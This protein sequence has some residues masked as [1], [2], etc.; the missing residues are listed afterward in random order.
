M[1]EEFNLFRGYIFHRSQNTPEIGDKK[2]LKV[3]ATLI[4]ESDEEKIIEDTPNWALSRFPIEFKRGGREWDP[5]DDRDGH[6]VESPALT[7]RHVR[8]QLISYARKVCSYQHRT[9]LL[10]LF[11][12]GEE[13]RMLHWDRS[14]LAFTPA[15]NYLESV[16]NMRLLLQFLYGFVVL[17]D[18]TQGLD[19]TAV[20]LSKESCGWKRMEVLGLASR[21]DLAHEERLIPQDFELPAGFA[22]PSADASESPL[23][24]AG[25][26]HRDPTEVCD[27]SLDHKTL[28]P[29]V[30]PVWKYMRELFRQSITSDYP[31]YS[32]TVGGRRFLVAKPV[33]EA[34]G[35]VSRGT[36]GYIALD[37]ETQRFVFLKDAWRPF[38]DGVQKEGDV[39]FKL[40]KEGVTNV[41]T[42]IVHGDVCERDGTEQETETS[43]LSPAYEADK[44]PPVIKQRKIIPLRTSRPTTTVARAA[45]EVSADIKVAPLPASA[46][47]VGDPFTMA[48]S[49][50]KASRGVKRPAYGGSADELRRP[51]SGIRHLV[52]YR[53]VV[54]E[55]C[56]PSTAFASGR[57]WATVVFECLQAHQGAYEMCKIVHRDISVGN[58]LILPTLLFGS[59]GDIIGVIWI[60]V[61]TDWELAKDASVAYSRRQPERTGTWQFMSLRCLIDSNLSVTIPDELESFFHSVLYNAVRFLVHNFSNIHT[62]IHHY[63]DDTSP[64]SNLVPSTPLAKE[65]SITEGRIKFKG[66]TL[67][68]GG[69]DL[70]PMNELVERLLDLFRARYRVLRWETEQ[71]TAWVAQDDALPPIPPPADAPAKGWSARFKQRTTRQPQSE[72][73]SPVV[74]PRRPTKRDIQ[75]A[76]SLRTHDAVL[77]IF[78]ELVRKEGVWPDNDTVADRL[79]GYRQAPPVLPS[80]GRPAKQAKTAPVGGLF[81]PL[82]EAGRNLVLGMNVDASSN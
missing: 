70:H 59:E 74:D 16:D 12:N 37:W 64:D 32:I 53:I 82:A 5:F 80:T 1:N 35:M 73:R 8:G 46:P 38:Y 63:F 10:Q 13:F 40:N 6:D 56:L 4:A 60:G 61:L 2:H 11:I 43:K 55:V 19:H 39:L 52:H 22:L 36:R 21:T 17:D 14:G 77:D 30:T 25:H 20:P 15:V 51:G 44:S 24:D 66:K 47:A 28:R 69:R 62:F 75:L 41:P 57:T 58:M 31:R 27:P 48:S 33:F 72:L 45:Q 78:E 34:N 42:L 65:A 26:L 3:D 29:D 50:D 71:E 79:H 68:F 49:S 18:C 54:A 23:F 67:K 76:A 7:R 81:V 9:K